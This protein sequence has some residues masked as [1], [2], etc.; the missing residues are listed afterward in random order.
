M[1]LRAFVDDSTVDGSRAFVLAGY[2]STLDR[3]EA[4]EREWTPEVAG[5]PKGVH[6]MKDAWN[7]RGRIETASRTTRLYEIIKRHVQMEISITVP[8]PLLRIYNERYN[9]P[10]RYQNAYYIAFQ[11]I[12]S[13][14]RLHSGNG[15]TPIDFVFDEQ[16]QKRHVLEAWERSYN[17]APAYLKRV[18]KSDPMFRTDEAFIPLQA[19]DYVAWWIQRRY[20]D[21]GTVFNSDRLVPWETTAPNYRQL[22][23]QEN[24]RSM[25]R[26]MESTWSPLKWSATLRITPQ[27][28]LGSR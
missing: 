1:V 3:W 21:H 5:L 27:K 20:H 28:P 6:K 2:I 14:Y 19:A 26:Y 4:F 25:H 17:G 16:S 23:A 24:E 18:I 22:W 8:L 7:Q 10:K 9:V 11:R 12:I 13:L 15:R